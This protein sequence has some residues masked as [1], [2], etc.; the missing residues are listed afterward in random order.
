VKPGKALPDRIPFPIAPQYLSSKH[1]ETGRSDLVMNEEKQLLVHDSKMKGTS[2]MRTAGDG[3]LIRISRIIYLRKMEK[4]SVYPFF[5]C[6]D[7]AD[8]SVRNKITPGVWR[9]AGGG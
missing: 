7:I 9:W 1:T 2:T 5:L 6:E 8:I 3:F 4:A